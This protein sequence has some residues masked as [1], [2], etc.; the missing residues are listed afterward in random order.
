MKSGFTVIE[1]YRCSC[2]DL[3]RRLCW[4]RQH[5]K[6]Q[7]AVKGHHPHENRWT[8]WT[9]DPDGHLQLHRWIRCF[10]KSPQPHH[11]A[12]SPDHPRCHCGLGPTEILWFCCNCTLRIGSVRTESWCEL[13][14]VHE[15][16]NW[17]LTHLGS[18]SCWQ[19]QRIQFPESSVFWFA[20][21]ERDTTGVFRKG[22]SDPGILCTTL[23]IG[24]PA[25]KIGTVE[26]RYSKV[27]GR[28][29]N[30]YSIKAPLLYW[31]C[32]VVTNQFS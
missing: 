29:E 31:R 13:W 15:W 19:G 14:R 10:Q 17:I 23:S 24:I 27:V 12:L 26:L 4:D 32:Y 5:E 16:Q 28:P 20:T 25:C 2:E 6:F 8:I 18:S 1:G 7:C 3:R 11:K 21:A 30:L 9:P 22:V